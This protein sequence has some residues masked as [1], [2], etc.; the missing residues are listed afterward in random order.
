MAQ[1]ETLIDDCRALAELSVAELTD[2]RRA[3]KAKEEERNAATA[4]ARALL[5]ELEAPYVADLATLN[6]A[7]AELV[8]AAAET[9][10]DFDNAR[11]AELLAGREC[12]QVA[13]PDGVRVDWREKVEVENPDL[14]PLAFQRIAPKTKE[15]SAAIK[16]G[17]AV[18]GA[19]VVVAP[20]VVVGAE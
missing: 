3:R 15:I 11:R 6:A 20:I 19:K 7:E 17:L 16:K 8:A 5:A 12:P 18:K 13:C 9:L 10:T 4:D 1:T 2:A 14:L